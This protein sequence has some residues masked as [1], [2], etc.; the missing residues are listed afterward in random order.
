[1]S[2]SRSRPLRPP[3]NHVAEWFGHRVFPVVA[4]TEQSLRDQQQ[5]CCPFLS[6]ITGIKHE[7]V[8]RAQSRGVCT[9]SST[10]NGSRQDWL[11]CPFR[12]L[13]LD[14]LDNAARRLFYQNDQALTLNL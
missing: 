8:K 4:A 10:S 11:V 5:G 7:C 1:M 12:A 3:G 9:I 13:D 6:D 14:I 2:S